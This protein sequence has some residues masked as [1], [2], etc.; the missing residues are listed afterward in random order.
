MAITRSAT[1]TAGPLV[2]PSD[3]WTVTA[4][5][6]LPWASTTVNELPV[7]SAVAGS[8]ET[9]AARWLAPMDAQLGDRRLH[10]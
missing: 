6:R 7:A 5:V 9:V 4:I 1:A 10:P 3:R 2:L 8:P